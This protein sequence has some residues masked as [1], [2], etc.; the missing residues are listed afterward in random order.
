MTDAILKLLDRFAH[1]RPLPDDLPADPIPTF[2]AW[3][4]E[5][6]AAK[7]QPNPNCMYLATSTPD[8]TPSVRTVLCKGIDA[9]GGS[10]EFYTNYTSRKAGEIERPDAPWRASVLFHWD[11]ADRQVRLEGPVMRVTA[12]ASDAYFKSR[13]WQ[14]RLGA[15]A[16]DQ[17]K[18]IASRGDLLAKV[19]R[20]A[21]Q[22]LGANVLGLITGLIRER[23]VQIPRPPHWGGYRLFA[24]SV[25]LWQGGTGRVHDRA[26]WTRSLIREGDAFTPGSWTSTR[27]QP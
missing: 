11:H 2:K 5:A 24:Q 14:S 19:A 8:G 20:A 7:A 9:A 17:S 12:E 26:R 6:V 18:P 25:E 4:D 1:D 13:H 23:D 21:A 22:H 27:L 15:W 16:S 10:I 3:F